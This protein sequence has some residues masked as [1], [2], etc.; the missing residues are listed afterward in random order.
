VLLGFSYVFFVHLKIWVVLLLLSRK[1][2]L[3]HLGTRALT[4]ARLASIPLN[5]VLPFSLLH[6][7][8]WNGKVLNFH[9]SF[10]YFLVALGFEFRA[11]HLQSRCSTPRVTPLIH[12][13]LILSN[14]LPRLASNHDP[15]NFCL[16]SS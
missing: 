11:S 12:F 5:F 15:L 13:A 16:L 14:Y 8:I 1:S 6:C 4:N 10:F 7:V 9:E 2:S 3:Y